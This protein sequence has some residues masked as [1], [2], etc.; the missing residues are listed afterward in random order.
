MP[1]ELSGM[2]EMLANL[3]KTGAD[4]KRA[5][6]KTLRKGAS[7]IRD[8]IVEHAHFSK[9]FSKGDIAKNIIMVPDN[10]DD[11]EMSTLVGPDV[12]KVP[13]AGMVEF[14]T[15]LMAA[16]PYIEP[17]FLAKREEA[18]TA[19]ADVIRGVIERS[20]KSV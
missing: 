6:I 11:G 10:T 13:Y 14:G 1:F 2:K 19:M 18:L 15:A 12:S 20:G 17:G 4:V 7:I 8:G 16:Q 5:K 9:G 3:E